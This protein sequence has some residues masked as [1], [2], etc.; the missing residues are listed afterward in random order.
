L[1]WRLLRSERQYTQILPEEPENQIKKVVYGSNVAQPKYRSLRGMPDVLPGCSAK[2]RYVEDIAREV[3]E[4]YGF[5]EIRTPILEATEVFTTGVG[6]STDIV[7]KEMYTFLDRGGKSV[8]LRPEGTASIIRA[9]VEH[10]LGNDSDTVKLFYAG[11]MFRG[12]R[13]QKGRLR[14]FHQIGAEI[15]GSDDPYADAEIVLTLERIL[16][17]LGVSDHTVSVNSLGCPYDREKYAK[18]LS[19]YLASRS[20]DLCED[21]KRRSKEN[22][23]RV[24]DCKSASCRDVVKGVPSITGFLCDRCVDAY[25]KFKDTLAGEGIS[26]KEKSDLVRGLDYYTGVIFEVSHPALGAQDAIAAGG[27]YDGLSGRMGGSPANATGY[28]IGVERLLLT[29]SDGEFRANKPGVLV[30]PAD[31]SFKPR[32]FHFA[33]RLRIS[34]VSCEIDLGGRSMKSQMRKAGKEKRGFVI[35]VDRNI[36]KDDAVSLKNMNTGVQED[37]VFGDIAE[38]IRKE[39]DKG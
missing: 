29:L 8:S 38:K 26:F 14:Q 11:P 5:S 33:E 32:A 13:P 37:V 34:G 19:S 30:I 10:G 27:R 12:E 21:C 4:L 31:E 39:E 16:S 2:M 20:S 28:A 15:I 6:Q 25:K 1:T 23:L 24:L 9:F 22:V 18:E 36:E 7:E 17:K 35:F 3:F